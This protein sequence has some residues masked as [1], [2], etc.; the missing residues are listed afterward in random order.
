MH[1]VYKTEIPKAHQYWSILSW[2]NLYEGY[3]EPVV[4]S[5]QGAFATNFL[6]G[7]LQPTTQLALGIPLSLR[8][9]RQVLPLYKFMT[10]ERQAIKST[11]SNKS[12][13]SF[14]PPGWRQGPSS[15]GCCI[16]YS[17]LLCEP[18][19][20]LSN[21]EIR[22]STLSGELPT[23]NW[24]SHFPAR[25]LSCDC[26]PL[27]LTTHAS[28]VEVGFPPHSMITQVK[29]LDSMQCIPAIVFV[30]SRGML[31]FLIWGTGL[32][33]CRRKLLSLQAT[34]PVSPQPRHR[35]LEKKRDSLCIARVGQA[36]HPLFTP[37]PLSRS[38]APASW[39]MTIVNFVQISVTWIACTLHYL[40]FAI[41]DCCSGQYYT[42]PPGQL[43]PSDTEYLFPWLF[44]YLAD[45]GIIPVGMP[46]L[47]MKVSM[48]RFLNGHNESKHQVKS[49]IGITWAHAAYKLTEPVYP[50]H[51]RWWTARDVLR[52]A[53]TSSTT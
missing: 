13:S 53:L 16:H 31:S 6:L 12:N 39:H 47:H 33:R 52:K 36:I 40:D 7:S 3:I 42:S 51:Q 24:S 38:L 45:V 9:Y 20:S 35:P 2:D 37:L 26:F 29:P 17:F 32:Y 48:R 25:T 28:K 19:S 30:L 50:S 43:I 21:S 5:Q 44:T 22:S 46:F 27:Q 11:Q 34:K 1:S 23:G 8:K 49:M 15:L 4:Q 41:I 10:L 14:H 18:K